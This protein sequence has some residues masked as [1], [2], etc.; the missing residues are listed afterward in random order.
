M[1]PYVAPGF[2]ILLFYFLVALAV[3]SLFVEPFFIPSDS[4]TPTLMAGDYVF[5]MKAGYGHSK[6]SFTVA[7]NFLNGRFQPAMPK[8]GDVVVFRLP[9]DNGVSYAKR[10]VGLPGDSVQLEDGVLYVNGQA[11]ALRDEGDYTVQTLYGPVVA[12]EYEETLPGG[13]KEQILKTTD[14]GFLNNTPVYTVPAGELFVL[15]DN[16]DDSIDSRF[17]DIAYVPEENVVGRVALI[18]F[19]VDEVPGV[20]Q[21]GGPRWN[22]IMRLVS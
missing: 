11:A 7:L 18:F 22:R 17:S 13:R 16:R 9:Q 1:E 2:V 8:R 10:V 3:Q 4:M 6:F 21:A 15:G 20:A 12:R 19:S 14:E 5:V